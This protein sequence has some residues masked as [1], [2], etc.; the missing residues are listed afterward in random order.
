V[1]KSFNQQDE[2]YGGGT[3]EM[4]SLDSSDSGPGETPA[5]DLTNECSDAAH[6][7]CPPGFVDIVG[8]LSVPGVQNTVGKTIADQLE[9]HNRSVS[10]RPYPEAW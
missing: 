2:L 6:S 7:P 4:W 3:I 9:E 8:N 10:P 1:V 5:L